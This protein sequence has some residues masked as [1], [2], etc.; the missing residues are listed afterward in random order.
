MRRSVD[1]PGRAVPP[2]PLPA[3]RIARLDRWIRDVRIASR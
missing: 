2:R 1:A 3:A